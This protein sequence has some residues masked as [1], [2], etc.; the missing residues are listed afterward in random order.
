MRYHSTRNRYL[1]VSSAQA[2]VAGLSREGGLFVPESFPQFTLKQIATMSGLPYS[3]RAAAVLGGFLTDFSAQELEACAD[4]AYGTGAFPR[5]AAPLVKVGDAHVLE[6][7]HGPTCAFKDFA[8][9]LMPHLL[10]ASVAKTG[11]DKTMV[12]LVAT[13]GDTGKAALAGFADVP[14][15]K[16]CVFYPS[17]AISGIQRRQ[18]TT[19]TGENV[20]VYAARG[21]FDAAQSGVKRIFTDAALAHRLEEKGLAF[22]SANSINWGRLAP[23]IAYY[24]SAYCDML[25]A[26]SIKIGDKINIVVPT[27]NFGNILAAWIAGRCGLPVGKLICASNSNNVLTD[28]ISTGI[29]NRNRDFYVTASPSMDILV[30]SNLERLLYFISGQDDKKIAALMQALAAT[31]KYTVDRDLHAAIKAQFWAGFA[32]DAQTAHTIKDV[33]DSTG[34]LCDTHTAVAHKVWQDYILAT[35]DSAPTVIASTASPFKFASSVLEALGKQAPADDFATLSALEAAS[36]LK[37][38][39]SLTALQ[40]LVERFEEAI[41]PRNMEQAVAHWLGL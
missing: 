36:G 34:Y 8:L 39:V 35:G 33:F 15:T 25:A 30:S 32:N 11:S 28:F 19:Q 1:A 10:T 20:M 22:S 21:N 31:G 17:G 14:G 38:P 29:Y 4:A 18:M 2:I 27:G 23:Q 7:F 37:A 24:F 26:G 3:K 16:I 9:Q 40:G 41:E 13:S 6:L 5:A 12:I